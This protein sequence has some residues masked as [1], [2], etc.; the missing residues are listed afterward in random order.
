MIQIIPAIDIIEGKC[1][2]LEQG[3]YRLKKV[4]EA[5]PLDVALRFQDHG[6]KRLHMVDL[7]GARSKHVVNW[8]VLE[9]ISSKTSLIIDFGGGIKTDKDLKIIFENGASMATIGSVAITD[10]K[11]FL[12]WMLAYGHEKIILID[13]A[14]GRE[15]RLQGR[16]ALAEDRQIQGHV[17]ERDVPL[18]RTPDDPR[19]GAVKAQRGDQAEAKAGRG[20]TQR[21]RLVLAEEFVE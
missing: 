1:V 2:R 3:N 13:V 19:V 15:N 11:L 9:K 14:Q 12:S 8:K 16:L 5:D 21:Q 4:Y 18:Y 6:I 17:P 7:D 20:S 10:K